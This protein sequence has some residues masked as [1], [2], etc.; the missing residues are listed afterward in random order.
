[1]KIMKIIKF[2]VVALVGVLSI[3]CIGRTSSYKELSKERDSL[4][5]HN[6]ELA[7]SY[8][9]T[10]AIINDIDAGFAEIRKSEGMITMELLTGEGRNKSKR[11]QLSAEMENLNE[12]LERNRERISQLQSSL[13]AS[14]RN[15]GA[16]A[17][18]L[19]RVQAELES[20]TIAVEQLQRELASRRIEIKRL[21]VRVD[22]LSTSVEQLSS[23]SQNQSDKIRNQ[24]QVIENQDVMLNTV[25]YCM[26]RER[27]LKDANII[28]GGGLLGGARLLSSDYDASQ[29]VQGDMRELLSI[30]TNSKRAKILSAHP[31]GSYTLSRGDDKLI[32][33]EIS[34][35]SKFWSVTKY[36]V[37]AL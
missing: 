35:P 23:T 37:I 21:N 3:S 31:E 34:D 33:L 19:E 1:M 25:W 4:L 36:L 20:K 11:E 27:D 28:S 2:L 29:F 22:S 8:D 24:S 7:K 18:T 6:E 13:S 10:L 5:I 14:N 15:N 16:L 30:P 26:A 17:Q 9:Q 12:I 32:T